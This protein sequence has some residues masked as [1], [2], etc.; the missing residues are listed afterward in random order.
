[1]L[2]LG[3][4]GPAALDRL[5]SLP[6][7]EHRQE[8]SRTGKGVIVIDNTFSSNPASAASSL[9]L[10]RRL[11]EPGARGVL[12]TPGMVELGPLQGEENRDFA[13][14]ADDAASDL[15]IVGQTNRKALEAGAAHRDIRVHYAL[16][17][18]RAVDWVRQRLTDGDVVLYENDLPDHYP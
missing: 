1:V 2:A 9:A 14:A 8:V 15:I 7:P 5:D 3:L 17:R 12:V 6:V 16:N 18:E 11:R 13:V 4:D 10:L